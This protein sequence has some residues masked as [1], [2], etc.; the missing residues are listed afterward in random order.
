MLDFSI[1]RA[2]IKFITNDNYLIKYILVFLTDH[3]S[4][5]SYPL[6]THC[7]QHVCWFFYLLHTEYQNKFY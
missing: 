3:F 5:I 2:E 6:L 1:W 4:S 7:S